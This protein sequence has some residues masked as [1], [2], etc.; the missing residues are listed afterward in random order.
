ARLVDQGQLQPRTRYI[1]SEPG[2]SGHNVPRSVAYT[3]AAGNI[4]H[5]TNFTP[6]NPSAPHVDP[7]SNIDLTRPQPGVTYKID[8]GFDEPHI[9][10]GKPH[11]AVRG[12]APS[13]TRFDPPADATPV[14][15]PGEYDVRANGP[16]SAQP[17]LPPNSRIE[18]RG[19]GNRLHGVFWT[20]ENN[21]VTHVRTWYGD[22]QHGYNPELGDTNRTVDKWGVPRPDTHYL[23]EPH[24]RFQTT[25]PN[26]PLDPPDAARSGDFGNNGVRPGTFLFHTDER[27]QTDVASGRPEY[28]TPHSDGEQRNDSVQRK[29]GHLGR[30]SSEYPGGRFDGGHIFPHEARGPGERIN[31]FPQW[32]PTN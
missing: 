26:P 11:A 17:N 10:T 29:T 7:N 28:D 21:R 1:V 18:V 12:M 3:D 5:V 31:Y 27:A 22:K 4:T 8:L 32:S 13:A 6:E 16:F 30:G 20:D 25:D 14:R 23:V 24:D 9:F 19:P 15:W 2:P